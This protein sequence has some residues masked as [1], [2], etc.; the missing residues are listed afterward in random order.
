MLYVLLEATL[1]TDGDEELPED[2]DEVAIFNKE[3]VAPGV[4]MKD[5]HSIVVELLER[6]I[7]FNVSPF[8]LLPSIGE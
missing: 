7:L 2:E 1:E 5:F 3:E 6:E 8:P 4:A